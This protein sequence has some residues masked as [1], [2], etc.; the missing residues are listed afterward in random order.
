MELVSPGIGLIFWMVVSFS[1]LLF[2]LTRFAWKPIMKM[3]KERETSIDEALKAASKARQEMEGLQADHQ[4]LIDEAKE[5]RDGI[6]KEARKLREKMLDDSRE[7]ALVEYNR[8]LDQARE[9]IEN[10][11]KAAITELRNEVATLSIEIAEKL[12]RQKM[13][14]AE[15]QDSF[16]RKLID[17]VKIN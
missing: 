9:A 1:I 12:M 15:K 11:K 3:I 13:S 2:V 8:M 14:E 7:K 4:K 17:E 6:L 10:E 5:E 16:V